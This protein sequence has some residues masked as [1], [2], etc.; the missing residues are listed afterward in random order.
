VSRLTLAAVERKLLARLP[1]R[2]ANPER[3]AEFAE[4]FGQTCT[5]AADAIVL[6]GDIIR[7]SVL[8]DYA[9]KLATV[10]V[11]GIDTAAH[12]MGVPRNEWV[13]QGQRWAAERF[14]ARIAEVRGLS[15]QGGRA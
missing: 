5:D 1:D 9:E 4:A 2:S 6:M 3:I 11:Y 7:P 15:V 14:F 8:S 12:E 13:R 10:V